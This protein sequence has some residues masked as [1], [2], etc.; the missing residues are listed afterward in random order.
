[1][2]AV[3]QR[4]TQNNTGD[5]VLISFTCCDAFSQPIRL[6]RLGMLTIC[7]RK[8]RQNCSDTLRYAFLA[9][10]CTEADMFNFRHVVPRIYSDGTLKSF[11]TRLT[12]LRQ[13]CKVHAL[14]LAPGN[15]FV[16]SLR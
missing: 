8:T 16:G 10:T 1:M 7:Q 11:H 14:E 4:K 5:I 2:V 13:T 6:P 9:D 12:R 15:T 3:C